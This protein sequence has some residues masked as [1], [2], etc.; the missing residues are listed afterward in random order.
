[1]DA[2]HKHVK[3]KIIVYGDRILKNQKGEKQ[4]EQKRS[5]EDALPSAARK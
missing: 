2:L 3:N 1:V 4:R 5:Q